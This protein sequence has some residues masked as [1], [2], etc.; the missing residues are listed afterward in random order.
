MRT[1]ERQCIMHCNNACQYC[2]F[3]NLKNVK[4]LVDIMIKNCK[5]YTSSLETVVCSFRSSGLFERSIITFMKVLTGLINSFIIHW[6]FSCSLCFNNQ[7]CTSCGIHNRELKLFVYKLFVNVFM[8]SVLHVDTKRFT[9]TD[10]I[11]SA[12]VL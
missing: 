1:E 4:I 6:N 12:I 9:K 5:N 2:G 10:R 3:N 8:C 11:R 7:R